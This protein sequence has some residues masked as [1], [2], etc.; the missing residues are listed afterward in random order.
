[1][2][3][4]LCFVVFCFTEEVHKEYDLSKSSEELFVEYSSDYNLLFSSNDDYDKKFQV[5]KSNHQWIQ[6]L[7]QKYPK[8][9]FNLNKFALFTREEFKKKFLSSM[10]PILP[11]DAPIAKVDN[12]KDLP[13]SFDW[14]LNKSIVTGVKDQ[15]MC[16]SCWAFSTIA[17]IEGQY[18]LATGSLV[19]LSEQ[20]LVDCDHECCMYE[21]E[22][23][24]DAGCDG[25]LPP[26]AYTY[27]MK[28]G[29]IASEK[30]Y[31]YEGYDNNC[32]YSP[33]KKAAYI[34]NWTMLSDDESKFQSFLYTNGPLSV[35]VEADMWQ[36]YLTGVFYLPCGTDL[37]HAV[38]LTGWGT[39]TDILFR[40]MP[41]WIIKNSWGT[42]WGKYGYIWLERNNGRCGVNKY[43][44]TSVVKK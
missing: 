10:K 40:T 27:V 33:D 30:N 34:S 39:E 9:K 6:E 22:K 31:P 26:N 37:D 11:A 14:A 44:T 5:F 25:G 36:F 38:L 35:A 32:R 42:G 8:T 3:I 1:L 2:I 21:N 19:S 23:A 18:A 15:G 4:L 16:G 13:D 43:V 41:Y 20:N 17:N 29:G 7:N 24:C 12:V 28:N